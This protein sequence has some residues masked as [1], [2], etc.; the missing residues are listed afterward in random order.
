MPTP[1]ST[2]PI[3]DMDEQAR[4]RLRSMLKV[5]S[6]APSTMVTVPRVRIR[7]P[8]AGSWRKI[9]QLMARI[10]QTPD[11]VSTPESSADA[12]A[13]AT[14]WALGSQMCRGNMPALAPKP[15][16]MQPPAIHRAV[17]SGQARARSYRRATSVVPRRFWSRNR[18]IS[19]TRPPMTATAR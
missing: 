8:Q 7:V 3:W 11:L 10:P 17:L 12:G 16:R 14:G 2:K 1:T 13:G 18:P 19:A 4:V 15:K 6:T 9:L 5:A